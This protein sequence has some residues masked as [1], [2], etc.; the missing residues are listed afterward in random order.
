MRNWNINHSFYFL[1]VYF[2]RQFY[3]S[4]HNVFK[5]MRTCLLLSVF[6]S[7]QCVV[8]GGRDPFVD[9]PALCFCEQRE[10]ELLLVLLK[11]V[12]VLLPISWPGSPKLSKFF[13]FS[14]V[15]QYMVRYCVQRLLSRS[16]GSPRQL[17][18]RKLLIKLHNR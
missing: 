18:Q 15:A 3:E 12:S 2:L 7:S 14:V 8:I 5:C 1:N 16:K 4:L 17:L 10:R 11:Y 6:L 13:W 9:R